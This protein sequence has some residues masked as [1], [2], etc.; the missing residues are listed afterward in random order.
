MTADV[1]NLTAEERAA[2]EAY[3]RKIVCDAIREEPGKLDPKAS[4]VDEYH[5]DSMMALGIMVALE[6]TF[7]LY[8]PEDEI[9]EF[10][11]LEEIAELTLRY[12]EAKRNGTAPAPPP[13]DPAPGTGV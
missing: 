10:D 12:V 3:V 7:D 5:I 4:L 8:I 1:K 9:A 2:I 6:K 11:T 13:A